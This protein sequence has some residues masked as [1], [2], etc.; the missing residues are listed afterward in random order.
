M[1]YWIK[2]LIVDMAPWFISIVLILIIIGMVF[3]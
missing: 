1:W 3:A 2:E